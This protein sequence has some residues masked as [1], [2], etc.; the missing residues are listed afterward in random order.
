ML[1]KEPTFH[2]VLYNIEL[3]SN[4]YWVGLAK[5]NTLKGESLARSLSWYKMILE[6]FWYILRLFLLL[7]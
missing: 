3:T 1:N 6:A 5:T 2:D 7:L 4:S